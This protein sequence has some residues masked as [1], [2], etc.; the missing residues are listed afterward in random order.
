MILGEYYEF[1]KIIIGFLIEYYLFFQGIEFFLVGSVICELREKLVLFELD[2][3]YYF[4]EKKE[5]FD[6]VIEVNVIS[7]SLSKLVKY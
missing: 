7:G 5:Y 3:F 6:L 1:I 4:G 2:E